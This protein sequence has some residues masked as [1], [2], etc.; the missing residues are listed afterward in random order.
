MSIGK[1]LAGGKRDM[2]TENALDGFRM[3]GT[4][5]MAGTIE[6]GIDRHSR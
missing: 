6:R 1:G 2:T 4:E 5:T 3:T